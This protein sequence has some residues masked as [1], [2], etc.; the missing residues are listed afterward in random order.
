MVIRDLKMEDF[1]AV[2]D[3]FMQLHNFHAEQRHDIYRKLEKSATSQAG[4]YEAAMADNNIMLGAE[5]DGKIIGYAILKVYKTENIIKSPRTFA[6]LKEI[7]V[8]ENYRR[9][10]IATA[11]YREGAKRA[12]AQGATSLEL[13]V[14]EFNSDA[15]GFYQ[16]LGMSVQSLKLEQVL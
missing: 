16:S 6:Y 8:D 11:L 1:D 14:W 13:M 7:A 5:I 12:K 15:I 2:N 10:G 9:K 3:L 4:D